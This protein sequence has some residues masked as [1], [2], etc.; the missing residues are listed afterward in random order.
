MIYIYI[1]NRSWVDTRWQQY[2]THLHTNNTQNTKK[3]EF[4]Q[5]GPWPVVVSYTLAF[6]LQLRK[7]H[8]N[9][10]VRVAQY[11][12]N[13]LTIQRRKSVTQHTT[14]NT[15]YTTFAIFSPFNEVITDFDHIFRPFQQHNSEQN[16]LC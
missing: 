1:Y 10:S 7:K 14:N 16:Q 12:N 3:G 8:G 5:C 6:A 9:P 15:E 13:G 4:G 2:I 11:K